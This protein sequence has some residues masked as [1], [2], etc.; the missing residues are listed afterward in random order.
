MSRCVTRL[1]SA[2]FVFA[3]GGGAALSPHLGAG[4]ISLIIF[5]QSYCVTTPTFPA[6]QS[7]PEL[8]VWPPFLPCLMRDKVLVAEQVA[9]QGF[10]ANTSR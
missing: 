8:Q 1:C 6:G 4:L 2:P 5:T 7:R 3:R 10:R 9:T